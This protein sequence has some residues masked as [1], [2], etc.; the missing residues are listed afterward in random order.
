MSARGAPSASSQRAVL[1]V[2]QRGRACC[3]GQTGAL[4]RVRQWH[5]YR[6]QH[7]FRAI[8]NTRLQRA[9]HTLL[10][11]LL[12]LLR[13]RL[14]R[15]LCSEPGTG[16]AET[17]RRHRASLLRRASSA[18]LR[19]REAAL[20]SADAGVLLGAHAPV[21]VAQLVDRAAQLCC[22][23]GRWADAG[24]RASLPAPGFGKLALVA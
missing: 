23:P 13:V 21:S 18:D 12:L 19:V 14:S 3:S 4:L 8:N 11:L 7:R 2:E 15:M 10:L 1:V 6:A 16:Y 20:A 24:L 5:S 17:A 22:D 9:F